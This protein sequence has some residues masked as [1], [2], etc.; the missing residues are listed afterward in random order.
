MS[1]IIK[2]SNQNNNTWIPSE[3]QNFA[4]NIKYYSAKANDDLEIENEGIKSIKEVLEKSRKYDEKHSDMS[5]RYNDPY[6]RGAHV[7]AFDAVA[8]GVRVPARLQE[9]FREYAAVL[10]LD[11]WLNAVRAGSRKKH[12]KEKRRK[13]TKKR[14]LRK[15][16]KSKKIKNKKSKRRTKRR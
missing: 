14:K 16:R 15:P 3:P 10:D 1:S 7:A 11:L 5:N 6:V 9:L 2:F 8:N 13:R 12:K 4:N